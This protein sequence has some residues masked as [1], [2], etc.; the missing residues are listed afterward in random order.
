MI[1]PY[2]QFSLETIVLFNLSKWLMRLHSNLI[3][4]SWC[5]SFAIV[6]LPPRNM[7]SNLWCRVILSA[8][9]SANNLLCYLIYPSVILLACHSFYI[10]YF[11]VTSSWT[12]VPDIIITSQC[13]HQF[14]TNT[15]FAVVMLCFFANSN[16]TWCQST[17]S[18]GIAC[19][20]IN[21]GSKISHVFR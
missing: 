7:L 5:C 18:R 14:A 16:S 6:Q 15:T 4:G 9:H 19:A 21:F 11:S 2:L 17:P 13:P 8:C 3:L 1:S 12:K 20:L 10:T